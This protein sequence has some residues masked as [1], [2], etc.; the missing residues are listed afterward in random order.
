MAGDWR[1]RRGRT[2]RFIAQSLAERWTKGKKCVALTSCVLS[3][4]AHLKCVNKTSLRDYLLLHLVV[5]AWG[6]TAILGKLIVLAP[7]DL[8]AWRTGIAAVVFGLLAQ[9]HGGLRMSWNEARSFAMVGAMLGLHWI[10]FFWSARLATASVCLA[11][12]PTAML[13]C[14]L[15]EPLVDGTRRW[16]PLEMLVGGAMVGAVW[17]IYEVEFRY[18]EG[19]TVAIVSAMLAALFATFGK[20]QVHRGHWSVIGCLQMS[21]A[22]LVALV[23]RPLLEDG[24]LPELPDSRSALWLAFL[25]LICTVAAYAGYMTVLKRMSVFS[26]NVIYNME[27][28]YGIVLAALVFGKAEFMSGGFYL[29]AG[30]IVAIVV[31]MPWVNQLAKSRRFGS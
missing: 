22:C 6:F 31:A 30:I 16:K 11:A 14:S 17:L 15:I 13:W 9:R 8:V 7:V 25:A 24:L 27:P 28:V 3:S 10:L 29:G 1:L 21:G 18:W 12:M 4:A 19:F 2:G 20:Q 26:I 5:L 23:C